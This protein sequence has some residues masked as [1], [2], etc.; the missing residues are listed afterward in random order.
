MRDSNT[1]RSNLIEV[2]VVESKNVSLG[3][4]SK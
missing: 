1:A 3:K 2:G 4:E